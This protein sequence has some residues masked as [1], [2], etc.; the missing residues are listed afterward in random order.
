MRDVIYAP[1]DLYG[2]GGPGKV[3]ESSI[4]FV[5]GQI[6]FVLDDKRGA[7][8]FGRGWRGSCGNTRDDIIIII[9]IL[10]CHIRAGIKT[11]KKNIKNKK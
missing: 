11:Q 5:F 6:S 7:R 3:A 2:D 9:I 10:C 1:T 4:P 8:A